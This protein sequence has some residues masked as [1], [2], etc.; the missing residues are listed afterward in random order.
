[1]MHLIVIVLHLLVS[2][3]NSNLFSHY[4]FLIAMPKDQIYARGLLLVRQVGTLFE[5]NH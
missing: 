1:M 5:L 3:G 2:E 4:I